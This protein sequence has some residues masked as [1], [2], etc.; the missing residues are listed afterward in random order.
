MQA[1][2]NGTSFDKFPTSALELLHRY[3]NQKAP[4]S[5]RTYTAVIGSLCSRRSSV[6]RAQAWDTYAHMRYV[7]YPNP[8]VFLYTVMIR[9]CAFPVSIRYPS[10]PEKALDLWTEMIQVQRIN[11]TVRAYN[12]IIL[13]CAKSGTKM[14]VN[15]GFRLSRQMLDSNRDAQGYAAFRPDVS[16]FTA[17]LE[18]AKRLG[19]LGRARWLLAELVKGRGVHMKDNTKAS[20][21]INEEVMMHLFQTYATYFPP[22]FQ[23]RLL[24]PRLSEEE[25]APKR[26]E[27]EVSQLPSTVIEEEEDDEHPSFAHIPPQTQQEI[28]REVKVLFRRIVEDRTSTS[29]TAIAT[30]SLPFSQRKFKNV[31]IT[32]RLIA[33]YL[34]VFYVH[35]SI[36]TSQK[37]FWT[38]FEEHGL[39]RSL[40]VYVEAIERCGNTRREGTNRSVALNFA[41]D[42][43]IKWREAEEA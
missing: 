2:L 41:E 37:M 29:P 35:A 8:D 21:E 12:A 22:P 30:P 19:D 18:G 34:S 23:P 16:T 11:P 24:E 32:T 1:H 42:L 33:S 40:R 4:V 28:I 26:Q 25:C 38:I 13:A 14:Y 9:A 15:E 6:A 27:E 3:E 31:E 17:L 39:S 43:W 10:E 7:A 36:Q 5:M 20:I